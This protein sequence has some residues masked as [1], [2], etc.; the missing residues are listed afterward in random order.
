R[1]GELYEKLPEGKVRCFAC[2]HRCMIP[3]GRAGVCRVRFNSGGRLFVPTGYAGALQLDPIEKKPFFHALP[4]TLAFSF[5]MLGCDFHCGYCQN[6]VTSQTLR[7]PQAGLDPV[8][9]SAEQMVEGARR[10]GALT[11]TSTYNEPLITSEWAAE[12][13]KLGRAAGLATSYVSN[14]NGTPEVLDYLRPW[15]DFYKVDLKS[16]KPDGYRQLGGKLDHVLATIR[17][18]YERG[19][20]VEIVTLVVPGFNDSEA[21]LRDIARFLKG[22]SP[23]I[24]WHVTAFHRDYKMTNRSDTSTRQIIRGAEIGYEEGLHFV[25]AGNRPGETGELENTRCPGCGDTLIERSGFQILRDKLK[26]GGCPKCGMKIP[27]VWRMEDLPAARQCRRRETAKADIA[28]A[29][30]APRKK[31][32]IVA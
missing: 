26:A 30:E 7:D 31:A 27:G 20:W 17:M 32:T 28:T 5:G 13:F 18:L 2:G 24:P 16:F 6:W 29:V 4:G 1:E 15:V 3:D 12:I 21:E 9:V 10:S 23:D 25:Y 11:L 14:G 8:R 22:V 19:F